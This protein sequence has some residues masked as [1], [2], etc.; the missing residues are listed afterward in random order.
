MSAQHRRGRHLYAFL[1][2]VFDMSLVE[3]HRTHFEETEY[4]SDIFLSYDVDTGV[5]VRVLNSEIWVEKIQTR[6]IVV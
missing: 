3:F 6:C 1:K 5:K 4:T 2:M